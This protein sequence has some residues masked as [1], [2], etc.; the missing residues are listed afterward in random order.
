MALITVKAYEYQEKEQENI[1]LTLLYPKVTWNQG[2]QARLKAFEINQNI[3]KLTILNA[4]QI[5]Y[6]TKYHAYCNHCF[7]F[8]FECIENLPVIL[9]TVFALDST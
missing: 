5:D 7:N 4:E 6:C 1:R 3:S 2:E 9:T 8:W